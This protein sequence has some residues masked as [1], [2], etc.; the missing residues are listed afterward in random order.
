M[1]KLL[2]ASAALAMVAGTAQAQS[3]VTVYGLLDQSYVSTDA[4]ALA[5]AVVTKTTNTGGDGQ[6]SGSR[7][8]FRGTEDLGGGLKANFVFE[9]GVSASEANNGIA[10]GTRLGFVELQSASMGSIRAGRQVSPTKAV[11]DSYTTFA[12]ST[13]NVGEVAGG[14]ETADTTNYYHT[15]NGG[16]RVGNAITLLTPVMS[17]F[18]A[19]LQFAKDTTKVDGVETTR[20]AT[21]MNGAQT[22][23]D[24]NVAMV[25]ETAFG[26]QVTA[27]TNQVNYGVSYNAGA[28]SLMYG[29]ADQDAIAAGVK[30]NTE[31]DAIGASYKLG[32]ATLFAAYNKK[33]V[34]ASG[35]KSGER[36]DTTVG[37]NYNMGKWDLKAAYGEGEIDAIAAGVTTTRDLK[38]YQVGAVYNLSKRTNAY[39]AY[40]DS[41]TKTKGTALKAT[42]DGYIA[43]IRHSF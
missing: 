4:K 12:N 6:L 34:E 8:G 14:T 29:R 9:F 41:E 30:T 43:G 20:A 2:I 24:L 37:I 15:G 28:L 31:H 22:A 25:A 27:Q 16:D 18:Q 7:L 36:S 21:T 33:T 38:G 1:K 10:S 23:V 40:G 35:V 39:V 17:G 42:R 11:N 3:S 5:N 13:W 19:Q 32:A 26:S